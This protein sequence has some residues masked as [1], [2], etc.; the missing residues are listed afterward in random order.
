MYFSERAEGWVGTYV[1]T[2]LTNID[3]E[4]AR[5]LSCIL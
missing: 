1:P 5:V 3:D 4:Q 2:Y